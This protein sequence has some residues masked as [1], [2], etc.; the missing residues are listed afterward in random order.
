MS[1]IMLN[2][3]FLAGISFGPFLSL[4][5]RLAVEASPETH[6]VKDA[7]VLVFFTHAS[8][9]SQPTGLPVLLA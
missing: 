7:A 1:S 6:K 5:Q 4:D 3:P 8:M 9:T 2:L